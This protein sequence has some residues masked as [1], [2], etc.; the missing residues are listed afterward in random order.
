[1]NVSNAIGRVWITALLTVIVPIGCGPSTAGPES[2]EQIK[3]V[4]VGQIFRIYQRE[5]KPPPRGI[6]DVGS[7]A[8]ALPAAIS[9][10]KSGEVLVYWGAGLSDGPDAAST[11]LAYQKDVPENGGEVL[12]QDGTARKMTAEEFKAAPRAPGGKIDDVVATGKK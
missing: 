6:K 12:M 4:Q 10:L 3:I 2:M 7:L 8:E 9:S 11:V 5:Q 1:M